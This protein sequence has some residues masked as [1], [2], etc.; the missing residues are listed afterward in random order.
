MNK[1][2]KEV[3]FYNLI[4]E[5]IEELLNKI[6]VNKEIYL[7]NTSKSGFS[8]KLKQAIPKEKSIIFS[9]LGKK[10]DITGF[11]KKQYYTDFLIVEIKRKE[12]KLE[13]IYQT[14][15]YK[16]LFEAKYTFLISLESI[17]EKLKRL[18][19]S[20]RDILRSAGDNGYRFF[21]LT[22]FDEKDKEF[23]DWYEVN[24]FDTNTYWQ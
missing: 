17:P 23:I 12:I 13:D 18:C 4:K 16:E 2:K 6:I 19:K 14:K 11:V 21:A 22:Q 8:E 1:E 3:D 7:E 20:N 24:P 5:K 10:P 15:M 9:F